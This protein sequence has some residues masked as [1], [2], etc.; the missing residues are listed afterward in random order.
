MCPQT[1]KPEQRE[2][3][4][5]HKT[6]RRQPNFQTSYSVENVLDHEEQSTTPDALMPQL[7]YEQDAMRPDSP[8]LNQNTRPTDRN[9]P[10]KV[11]P[12]T[13]RKNASISIRKVVATSKFIG[14]AHRAR[15]QLRMQSR[16]QP[17]TFRYRDQVSPDGSFEKRISPSGESELR[18]SSKGRVNCLDLPSAS[19]D[20]QAYDHTPDSDMKDDARDHTRDNLGRHY[21]LDIPA[22]SY[23]R[24][25][26]VHDAHEHRKNGIHSKKRTQ[27]IDSPS[28][29]FRS[30]P[31]PRGVTGSF[32]GVSSI[33]RDNR[34]GSDVEE[35]YQ[36]YERLEK[37]RYSEMLKKAKSLRRENMSFFNRKHDS[38]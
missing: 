20:P 15:K 7:N 12:T 13:C 14:A 4:S 9:L 35:L 23:A 2:S 24:G 5:S 30:L 38:S 19:L 22:R 1:S 17:G 32:N 3:I 18:P 8:R 37:T 6:L 29:A 28:S 27:K 31:S 10:E 16:F 25:L 34:T 33:S 21:P 26:H 11:S 36:Q